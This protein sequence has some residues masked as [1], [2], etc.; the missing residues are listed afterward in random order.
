MH[1]VLSI[2][3]SFWW[4]RF[5][6]RRLLYRY[7]IRITTFSKWTKVITCLDKC[8]LSPHFSPLLLLLL[9]SV[10]LSS[11]CFVS[12]NLLQD[13]FECIWSHLSLNFISFCA[14]LSTTSRAEQH[15]AKATATGSVSF[16]LQALPR[17]FWWR[18]PCSM[19]VASGVA[20]RT[21]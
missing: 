9:F 18:S 12:S 4:V 8:M 19:V 5:K 20:L 14:H 13:K 16:I 7:V 21:Q 1:R 6:S 15:R 3:F 11:F 2:T 10:D 17:W